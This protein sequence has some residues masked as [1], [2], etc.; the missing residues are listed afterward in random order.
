MPPVTLLPHGCYFALGI[1]LAQGGTG[2]FPAR[3]LGLMALAMATGWLEIMTRAGLNWDR[4]PIV[5]PCWWRL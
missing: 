4:R 2:G 1:A 3:R 5:R